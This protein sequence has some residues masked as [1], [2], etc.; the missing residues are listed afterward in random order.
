[1]S[2]STLTL[3][4][5]PSLKITDLSLVDVLRRAPVPSTL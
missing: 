2:V 3:P 4:V 1:M 5:S